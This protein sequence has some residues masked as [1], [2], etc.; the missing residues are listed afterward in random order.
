[1]VASRRSRPPQSGHASTSRPKVRRNNSAQATWRR[2]RAAP[3]GGARGAAGAGPAAEDAPAASDGA[4]ARSGG[5]AGAGAGGGGGSGGG[6]VAAATRQQPRAAKAP[7]ESSRL[8]RGRGTSAASFSSSSHG[9]QRSARVPSRHGRRSRS[10]THPSDVGP[11]PRAPHPE[12]R[13]RPARRPHPRR[14]ARKP[15]TWVGCCSM[16]AR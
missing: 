1:M 4:A 6:A 15:E 10:R 3:P 11:H 9:S 2:G 16:P 14:H 13:P 5:P 7:W 8:A 12:R